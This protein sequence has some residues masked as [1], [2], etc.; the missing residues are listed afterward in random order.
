LINLYL[1]LGDDRAQFVLNCYVNSPR[2]LVS[3]NV[4]VPDKF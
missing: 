2:S 1:L 3:E 4:N